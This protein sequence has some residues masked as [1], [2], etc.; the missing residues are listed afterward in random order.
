MKPPSI[1]AFTAAAEQV[2][3][4]LY[5]EHGPLVLYQSSGACD[6]YPVVA[7]LAAAQFFALPTDQLLAQTTRYC[8]FLS[9]QEWQ[10]YA[11]QKIITDAVPVR[12]RDA[13]LECRY[14]VRFVSKPVTFRMVSA[15]G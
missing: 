13:S 12:S 11:C 9:G 5:A 15:E 7:C 2:I 14:H 1:V 8:Y 3:D 4:R 6:G 10:R